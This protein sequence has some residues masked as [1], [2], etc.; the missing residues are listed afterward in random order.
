MNIRLRTHTVNSLLEFRDA[1][2]SS[3]GYA[4]GANLFVQA[5]SFAGNLY[6]AFETECLEKFIKELEE[7]DRT[8]AGSATLKPHYENYSITLKLDRVG[9]IGVSGELPDYSEGLFQQLL[10]EFETDQTCLPPFISDLKRWRKT[11]VGGI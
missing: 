6:V 2:R 9:H 7:M 3:D 8:L 4:Y 5:R 1:A 11:P 10:F